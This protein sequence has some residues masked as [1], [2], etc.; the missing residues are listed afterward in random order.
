MASYLEDTLHMLSGINE[1]T[2]SL[3]R[4]SRVDIETRKLVQCSYQP[5][6]ASPPKIIYD[7]FTE[8]MYVLS[9]DPLLRIE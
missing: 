5:R 1:F 2:E 4:V 7:Q 8:E 3:A 6:M 9:V